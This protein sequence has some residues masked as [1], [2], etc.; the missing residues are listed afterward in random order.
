MENDSSVI[1]E[2]LPQRPPFLFVDR[3]VSFE[4]EAG[5]IVAEKDLPSGA[6]FFE[7]HFPERAVMPGVLILEALAQASGLL[8]GL[9]A[10]AKGAEGCKDPGVLFFLAASN[11]R[12]LRPC[13]PGETLRLESRLKK[14][15]GGLFLFDVASSV[16]TASAAKGVLTL[17]LDR[18]RS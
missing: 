2:I 11:I 1:R 15:Y 5:C 4:E 3:V 18:E 7:G 12:F 9:T 13:G 14:G 10:R 6:T 8:L 16:E 17:A